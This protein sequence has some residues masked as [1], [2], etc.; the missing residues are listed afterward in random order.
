MAEDWRTHLPAAPVV[1]DIT[2]PH[3]GV[4][5]AI[6]GEALGLAV[7]ALGGGRKVESD[8]INPAVGL[9]NMVCLGEKVAQNQPLCM[10]HAASEDAAQTAAVAVQNAVTIGR[11][12]DIAPLIRKEVS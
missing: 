11:G 10:V 7:V 9:T 2:A 4:V 1:G 12:A 8:R 5:T 6:D 3:A